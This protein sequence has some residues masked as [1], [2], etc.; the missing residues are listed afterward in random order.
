MVYP[1]SGEPFDL[2]NKP[3]QC[4]WC[5]ARE[6]AVGACPPDQPLEAPQLNLPVDPATLTYNTTY[7][8]DGINLPNPPYAPGNPPLAVDMV[9]L[10]DPADLTI[11]WAAGIG[12]IEA[13]VTQCAQNASNAPLADRE[14]GFW[15][16]GGDRFCKAGSPPEWP[17]AEGCPKHGTCMLGSETVDCMCG[18]SGALP[19]ENWP[20]DVLDDLVYHPTAFFEWAEGL[21]ARDPL[22]LA[23]EFEVWYQGA[24]EWIEPGTSSDLAVGSN[25]VPGTDCFEQTC[26]L[27]DG[28]LHRWR[29][30]IRMMAD[31]LQAWRDTSFAGTQCREVWCV[32]P[33][34]DPACPAWFSPPLAEAATFDVNANSIQ[35]DMEDIVACIKWN[36][37]NTVPYPN[38]ATSSD[39]ATTQAIGNAEKF[40]ACIQECNLGGLGVAEKC[41]DLPRSLVPG[42]DTRLPDQSD[43][44]RLQG[45]LN[46]CNNANCQVM[47]SVYFTGNPATTDFQTNECPTWGPG[48]IW[49]DE[50]VAA[51]GDVCDPAPGGWLDGI[52]RSYPEAQNQ[53]A[54]FRQRYTYLSGRLNELNGIIAV[55][56]EAEQKFNEFLTC[57]DADGD[58]KPDGHACQLIQDRINYEYE[59]S[60]LP[61]H[62]VYGWQGEPPKNDPSAPGRWHLVRVDARIPRKCDR[63]CNIDQSPTGDPSWP[64]VGTYTEGFLD[65]TRCY[66]MRGTEGVVKTRVTRFDENRGSSVLFPNGVPIWEFKYFHPERPVDYSGPNAYNPQGLEGTC[67]NSMVNELPDGTP[68]NIYQGAFILNERADNPGCWDRVQNILTRGVTSETCARYYWQRGMRPG[69]DFMFVP[70]LSF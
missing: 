12:K 26:K 53:V 66:E 50:I 64:W 17:Y 56:D 20:D 62:A 24:S 69:M 43:L 51:L 57:V 65:T 33:A 52:V 48:N 11:P 34:V 14:I 36:A 2:V 15:K 35:G 40:N 28:W 8:V 21:L 4:H 46:S 1:L 44:A 59:P 70:C 67:F 47:S 7:C 9:R 41:A 23:G 49:Y 58:G 27:E 22:E 6:V 60:G 55:L 18:Q 68:T 30:K 61:Y 3:H 16:K 39:P 25:A 37:N 13:E 54:K 32:P 31:R 38:A 10:P 19:E 29:K 45:C 5:D 63:A 42:V